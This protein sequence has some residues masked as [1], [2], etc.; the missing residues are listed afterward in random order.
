MPNLNETSADE[1][2]VE[3][4]IDLSVNWL[5]P[6]W[7]NL[8]FKS[9]ERGQPRMIYVSPS[10]VGSLM[11]RQYRIIV[12]TGGE[13]AYALVWSW[14]YTEV[15]LESKRPHNFRQIARKLS[16]LHG[17][18]SKALYDVGER[19]SQNPGMFRIDNITN[20]FRNLRKDAWIKGLR[21]ALIVTPSIDAGDVIYVTDTFLFETIDHIFGNYTATDLLSLIAFWFVQTTGTMSLRSLYQAFRDSS[22][23]TTE[24]A[25][26][27][28]AEEVA[29]TYSL[30]LRYEWALKFSGKERS[31]IDTSLKSIV[32][33]ASRKIKS[34]QWLDESSKRSF[35]LRLAKMTTSMWDKIIKR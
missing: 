22:K 7:F 10:K 3:V 31:R 9:A 33:V 8:R 21:K 18:I 29:S 30:L 16:K 23:E 34:L 35:L 2:M 19:P 11:Y 12:D 20:S 6:F 1:K 24:Y 4:L 5:M 25:P 32:Q 26:F 13:R 28:C 17:E 14:L 27:I 15:T